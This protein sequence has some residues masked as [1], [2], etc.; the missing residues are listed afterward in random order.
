VADNERSRRGTEVRQKLGM[1]TE[2]SKHR[3]DNIGPE[4]SGQ[5]DEY[6][7]NACFGDVWARPGLDLRTRRLLT[8]AMLAALGRERQLRGHIVGA[9]QQGISREEVLET[10]VHVI[11]YAGFPA[12]LTGLEIFR[13]AT[14]GG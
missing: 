12:G 7:N 5:V 2:A 3:F 6:L 10:I 8:I 14:K 1:D 11:P 4:F 13:E 9:L